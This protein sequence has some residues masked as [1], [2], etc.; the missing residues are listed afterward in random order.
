M[1]AIYGTLPK[2][3]FRVGIQNTM[4]V[5]QCLFGFHGKEEG[6]QIIMTAIY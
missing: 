2:N 1:A 3:I 5:R 4:A 6:V